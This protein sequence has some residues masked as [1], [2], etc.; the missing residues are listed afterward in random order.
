MQNKNPFRF[1]LLF[2]VCCLLGGCTQEGAYEEEFAERFAARCAE[3][4][5]E[6]A[7][8]VSVAREEETLSY[9]IWVEAADE[10]RVTVQK[11]EPLAGI[12]AHL[13]GEELALSYDGSVLDAGA[14]TPGLSAVN[15]VPLTFRAAA[16]GFPVEYGTEKRDG[17]EVLRIGNRFAVNGE[18][19]TV[20]IW[21]SQD[22]VPLSAE[23]EHAGRTEVFLRFSDFRFRASEPA[24]NTA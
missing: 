4:P 2:C 8:S 15:A 14:L 12:T 19:F 6:T 20:S 22:G 13:R 5:Y 9:D 7:A 1:C 11:P 23:W 3:E 17:E 24:E 10:V 18:D 21:F 16:E